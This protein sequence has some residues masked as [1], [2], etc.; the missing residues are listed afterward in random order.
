M[1]EK[2]KSI[3]KELL[4]GAVF[5]AIVTLLLILVFAVIVKYANLSSVAIKT[6]NQFIKGISVF[7]GCFFSLKTDRGLVKGVLV[8]TI[9]LVFI[10][11]LFAITGG[12]SFG[13]GLLFDA[14]ICLIIGGVS[15]IF[16][17]NFKR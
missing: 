2:S 8:G 1:S 10:Y 17:V 13:I 5:S 6:V 9:Y 11:V 15:G 4:F 7:I 12:F 3:I 16:A 14:L